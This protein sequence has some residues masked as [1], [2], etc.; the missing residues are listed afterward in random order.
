[1]AGYQIDVKTEAVDAKTARIQTMVST[2]GGTGTSATVKTTDGHEPL[3]R[4]P[5][6]F[7]RFRG[8]LEVAGSSPGSGV[9]SGIASSAFQSSVS[10][11]V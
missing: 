7:S 6:G 8:P 3:W 2:P 4:K 11:G 9:P 10:E 5:E 1:M